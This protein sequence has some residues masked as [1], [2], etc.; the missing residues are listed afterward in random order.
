MAGN[1]TGEAGVQRRPQTY[2]EWHTKHCAL[3]DDDRRRIRR[4]IEQMVNPPRFAVVISAPIDSAAQAADTARSVQ[5][6]LFP[7]SVVVRVDS[8]R[9]SNTVEI[10]GNYD[11]VVVIEAGARLSEHALYW[12]AEVICSRPDVAA[13]YGDED[14]I[15]SQGTHTLGQFKPNWS[16]EHLRSI[17]YIGRCITFRRSE[18]HAAGGIRAESL[19]DDGYE[20]NLRVCT[21]LR[22]D[23]VVHIPA[24]L[25]HRSSASPRSA[26]RP[27]NKYALPEPHPLVSIVIPTC[28]AAPLLKTCVT[29]V[30]SKTTYHPFELLVVDNRSTDPASL[31]YLRELSLRPEIRLLRYDRSFNFSAINNFAVGQANGQ[32]LVLLNNDTEVI[33]PNWIE[34]MLAQLAREGVGAV[35]AKLLFPDG[36]VQ[37]AGD[38]IGVRGCADHLH[39]GIPGDSP[40]YCNRAVV[41]QEVSAVTAACLMTWTRLYKE[42]NGLDE[43]HLPVAFNDVDFCLRLQTHKSKR[44]IFTPHAQLYHHESATRGKDKSLR[45]KFRAWREARHMRRKWGQRMRSDPYYNPNLSHDRA[46]FSLNQTPRLAKPWL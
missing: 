9:I 30:L 40:G 42:L 39:A 26:P 3:H 41:V 45:Q 23:Q 17:N 32:V 11:Y 15:D 8:H 28:D 13:A 18:L 20:L 7:P 46:N 27:R 14:T 34:E 5:E 43:T 21:T 36:R 19:E 25:Y 35:G 22:A 33:T 10:D 1:A 38:A 24:V 12:M 29:G 6:Q 37:H 44:V 16:P 2:G 31:A 4:R